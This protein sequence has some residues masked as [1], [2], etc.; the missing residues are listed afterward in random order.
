MGT[1]EGGEVR[2]ES[3]NVAIILASVRERNAVGGDSQIFAHRKRISFQRGARQLIYGNDRAIVRRTR[4]VKMLA[5]TYL[6][7]GRTRQ[8]E[9]NCAAENAA[10]SV[11]QLLLGFGGIVGALRRFSSLLVGL[12]VLGLVKVL[13]RRDSGGRGRRHDLL[14]D[15]A[16][17]CRLIARVRHVACFG[18]FP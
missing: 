7:H 8:I 16:R 3:V 13:S 6:I 17:R 2:E 10:Q 11:L 12:E 14:R 4:S 1:G 5:R 9:T 18:V 15:T